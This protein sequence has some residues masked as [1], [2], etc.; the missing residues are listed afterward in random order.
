[1]Y[2]S[3]AANQAR[4]NEMHRRAAES[5]RAA[6]FRRGDR[7]LRAA[8]QALRGSRSGHRPALRPARSAPL[9]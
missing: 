2:L 3:H 8:I 7:P 9:R 1:M 6:G 4:M 5:R